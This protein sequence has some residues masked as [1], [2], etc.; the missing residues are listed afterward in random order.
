MRGY[1][2]GRAGDLAVGLALLACLGCRENGAD[3]SRPEVELR[4]ADEPIH[5][6]GGEVLH[7]T[8]VPAGIF[9]C[10]EDPLITGQPGVLVVPAGEPSW[11]VATPGRARAAACWGETLLVADDYAGLAV[12][13][14]GAIV[15]RYDLGDR[16]TGVLVWGDRAVVT[17]WEGVL[18]V[19]SLESGAG[20]GVT[21]RVLGTL[22]LPGYATHLAFAGSDRVWVNLYTHGIV[23][24]DVSVPTDPERADSWLEYRMA[25]AMSADGSRLAVADSS[26]TGSILKI[27]ADGRIERTHE[28]ETDDVALSL[29]LAG[30]HLA[31]SNGRS[32][33]ESRRVTEDGVVLAWRID[34]PALAL[35]IRGDRLIAALSTGL[36][37]LDAGG[38]A[39]PMIPLASHAPY[40]LVTQKQRVLSMTKRGCNTLEFELDDAGGVGQLVA[41][42]IP[43][44]ECDVATFDPTHGWTLGGSTGVFRSDGTPLSALA[45][46]G[47]ATL[48]DRQL[49]AI[50]MRGSGVVLMSE[51]YEPLGPGRCQVTEGGL[52][53]VAPGGTLLLIGTL[54]TYLT[55]HSVDGEPRCE[56]VLFQ[57]SAMDA[58][59]AGDQ[60]F[61][62]ERRSGVEVFEL[63]DLSAGANSFLRIPDTN[64][65]ALAVDDGRIFIGLGDRGVVAHTLDGAE[66]GERIGSWETPGLVSDLAV[67][68]STLLVAD[69]GQLLA[70]PLEGGP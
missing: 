24:V 53:R 32:G 18:A 12:L 41:S 27:S 33:T 55:A 56:T 63:D 58:V 17:L 2:P 14:G 48:P 31:L 35:G 1:P 10:G 69:G 66:I 21:M 5:W 29:V 19:L 9:T 47:L 20:G 45:V 61:V 3:G 49:H 16:V 37:E 7:E 4:A 40:G 52:L 39:T 51:A 57:G 54:H 13:H 43:G 38:R 44:R 22:E 62:A 34:D 50:A 46:L 70:V 15:Q 23:L 42:V 28:F 8:F 60:L 65:T 25:S 6:I 36:V 11:S 30:D 67:V 64:P 68:G 26:R 59:V